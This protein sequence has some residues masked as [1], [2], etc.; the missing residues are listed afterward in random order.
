[1]VEKINLPNV[2]LV[3]MAGKNIYATVR[4]LSF[5]SRQINFG[6]VL[7]ISHIKP[8]YLPKSID[9]AYTSKTKSMHEWCYKIIYKLHEYIKT[10]YIILVHSDGFIVN[11][12]SWRSSFLDY[13][14]IGAPWPIPD[15][16]SYLDENKQLIRVGNSVSLRSRR[17]LEL[18]SILSLPWEPPDGFYHED[19]FLCCNVRNT[20]IEHGI[21]Y[22][23]IEVA[24]YFSHESMIPEIE[25][26]SPFAFH[27]WHGSNSGYP[28]KWINRLLP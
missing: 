16:D 9:Y 17:I 11:P 10:D 28:G 4:A 21:R 24:K 22:A 5:S 26:I 3:A 1:M 20:L 6:Q 12:E 13:D 2:T 18:P 27:K 8:W 23:P 14:Y 25:G 19:G 15:D 7:L